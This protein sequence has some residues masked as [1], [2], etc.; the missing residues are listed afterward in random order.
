MMKPK[1]A[2]PA[3]QA[4]PS[5][6]AASEGSREAQAGGE[7]N[8]VPGEGGDGMMDE[9]KKG[10]EQNEGVKE[11]HCDEGMVDLENMD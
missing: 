10:E 11:E 3:P 8:G 6:P 4:P 1:P 2:P 5:N 9:E 7:G